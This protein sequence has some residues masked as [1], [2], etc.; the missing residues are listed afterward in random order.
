MNTT[1]R[2]YIG[3]SGWSYTGWRHSFYANIPRS[4]W[5]R[6]CAQHF[7]ALEIN[8]SFYRLQR[9]ET[10]VRW[11]EQTPDRFRFAIKG[12]RYLT[13]NKKLIDPL[14]SIAT[15]KERAEGLGEKLA[16]VLWQLPLRFKKNIARLE[17]FVAALHFWQDARHCIEFRHPSW[18]DPEVSACLEEYRVAA[19]QSDAADWQLWPAVTTDLVYIRLHGHSRTY[20][21]NY[22]QEELQDWAVK[23]RRWL[24]EGRDV[25]VYFDNDAEGAAPYNAVQLLNLLQDAAPQVCPN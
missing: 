13:H 4:Q 20:A 7:T 22:N 21:S 2:L 14:A 16:V 6:F 11:K 10:F 24:N 8:A 9:K 25:H 23:I 18:F 12:N 19:C 5:L 3:T 15:E 1:P 17:T